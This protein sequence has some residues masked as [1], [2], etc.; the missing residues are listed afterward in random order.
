MT[1][2]NRSLMRTIGGLALAGIIGLGAFAQS[3]TPPSHNDGKKPDK[4][5]S[6]KKDKE[7]KTSPTSKKK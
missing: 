2:I 4:T 3:T 5:S 1:N 7:S 6:K